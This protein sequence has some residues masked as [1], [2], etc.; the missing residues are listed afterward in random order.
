MRRFTSIAVA[1]IAASLALG[2]AAKADVLISINK[3]SQ[4]MT[5][6]VDG[7]TRYTWPV[8]TGKMGYTTPSGTYTPFRMEATYFSKEW[9]DAPMPHAIFFTGRGHAIHG[10]YQ[11]RWLGSAVSHGCVRLAPGNATQLYSLVQAEGMGN[12]RVVITGGPSLGPLADIFGDGASSGQGP[13]AGLFGGPSKPGK[14]HK[15]LDR[16]SNNLDSFGDWLDG[17]T[18]TKK[19]H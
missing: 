15:V 1:F 16:L 4:R 19:R 18:G 14:P 3:L 12:T 5:V 13:L 11:T 6:S 17:K 10:T 9:D 7:K 8:S 2:S